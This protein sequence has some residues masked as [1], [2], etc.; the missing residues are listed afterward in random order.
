MLHRTQCPDCRDLLERVLDFQHG[1]L[2]MAGNPALAIPPTEVEW[3]NAL[4]EAGQWFHGRL[5][6]RA[7]GGARTPSDVGLALIELMTSF[8]VAPGLATEVLAAFDH[9]RQFHAAAGTADFRF[10]FRLLDAVVRPV[11]K[12]LFEPFY[13]DFLASGLPAAVLG[14]DKR[15]DRGDVLDRFEAA[16]PRLQVCPACDG[17]KPGKIAGRSLADLDHYLPK[18]LYPFLCLHPLNL[19]P[20]CLECNQ[21]IK[22]ARDPVDIHDDSP[23]Q[24][25][26]LPYVAPAI[27][28]VAVQVSRDDAGALD[29]T[30]L[31]RDGNRSRRVS[32]LDRVFELQ[33]RW[34]DRLTHEV[35]LVREYVK[36]R[37]CRLAED[38]TERDEARL[39][40]EVELRPDE[41]AQR[42]GRQ[43][44]MLVEAG[45]LHFAVQ[46]P[47]ELAVLLSYFHGD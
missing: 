16:N 9:D 41:V 1:V 11:L 3:M 40:R 33:G 47:D 5:S 42:F 35:E 25:T 43:A 24:N 18:S 29:L 15:L 12:R 2:E 34:Q 31:E 30:V 38:G 19:V 32:S 37:G 44:F 10:R 27:D 22:R 17:Q 45:Y 23:L 21:R 46:D 13:S 39:R 20:T 6:T 28:Q 4:G 8:R 26:F 14:G 36:E 7:R